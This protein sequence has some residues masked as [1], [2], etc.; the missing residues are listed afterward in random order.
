MMSVL[1]WCRKQYSK[2]GQNLTT[3][4]PYNCIIKQNSRIIITSINSGFVI[5]KHAMK[6]QLTYVA[7]IVHITIDT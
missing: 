3:F 2:C 4:S 6:I 5:I 7:I 1:Q